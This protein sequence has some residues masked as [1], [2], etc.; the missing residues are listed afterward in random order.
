MRV[1][2]EGGWERSISAITSRTLLLTRKSL[3][4]ILLDLIY[5]SETSSKAASSSP[6]QVTNSSTSGWS[7]VIR[8]Q[9]QAGGDQEVCA[10]LDS[11]DAS[12][13]GSWDCTSVSAIVVQVPAVQVNSH[14]WQLSAL[15][16]QDRATIPRTDWVVAHIA[17]VSIRPAPHVEDEAGLCANSDGFGAADVVQ[18]FSL[19]AVDE[20]E[21][22][23]N[24]L[25]KI[26]FPQT[27]LARV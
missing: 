7:E 22:F 10:L 5:S 13:R 23:T 12:V 19:H 26:H 18:H 24:V 16:L 11:A 4:A 8:R 25:R 27:L 2:F 9:R 15:K 14:V 20:V 17:S 21:I 6:Q 3:H 1:H